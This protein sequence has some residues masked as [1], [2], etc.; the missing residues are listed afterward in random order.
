MSLGS[1]TQH[2]VTVIAQVPFS[3]T[4]AHCLLTS[5]S[6]TL[7]DS[8]D[9][10][11]R[12][13]TSSQTASN[14]NARGESIVTLPNGKKGIRCSCGRIFSSGQ[15]LGGHRG[16]CKVPR[17]RQRDR[18]ARGR[19]TAA[20]VP[21]EP[22]S[23][24]P[25]AAKRAKLQ[26]RRT[27][28]QESAATAPTGTTQHPRMEFVRMDDYEVGPAEPL[29]QSLAAVVKIHAGVHYALPAIALACEKDRAMKRFKYEVRVCRVNGMGA[30]RDGARCLH[31]A[32]QGRR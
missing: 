30:G 12:S 10:D 1:R 26:R 4:V 25:S 6:L 20:G 14:T 29:A 13:T 19:A 2:S 7:I 11:A 27:R 18:E 21:Y 8:E 17:E 28:G 31:L 9:D 32:F 22:P 23:P 24:E 16:K 5:R 15:A 3:S